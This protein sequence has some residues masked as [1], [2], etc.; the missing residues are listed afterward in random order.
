MLVALSATA[1]VVLALLWEIAKPWLE[2][3]L[4]AVLGIDHAVLPLP[5]GEQVRVGEVGDDVP[6]CGVLTEL[7]HDGRLE[8]RL[9]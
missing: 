5:V 4:E 7:D 6:G 8:P 1:I 3:K 2:R 9:P